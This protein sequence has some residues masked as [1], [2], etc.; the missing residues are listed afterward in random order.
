M[1]NIKAFLCIF[2]I[3]LLASCSPKE[4]SPDLIV[5]T[6]NTNTGGGGTGGGGTGGGGTGGGGTGG[7][8]VTTEIF[9]ANIA[10]AVTG[11]F[12]A[13]F[14]RAT[15]SAGMININGYG[16]NNYS[17]TIEFSNT[18]ATSG[19]LENISTIFIDFDNFGTYPL[20]GGTNGV[21]ISSIDK[22]SHTIKGTFYFD[23]VDVSGT[24]NVTGGIFEVNY[25]VK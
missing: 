17:M 3:V 15:D 16:S 25:T 12:N 20:V 24:A 6:A 14:I 4:E 10:G 5:N 22:I 18:I 8:P 21:S 7:G 19:S 2:S 1:K 23:G 13:T 9:K 11:A